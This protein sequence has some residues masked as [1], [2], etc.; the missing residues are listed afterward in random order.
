M[1]P[2]HAIERQAGEPAA[3]DRQL[4]ELQPLEDLQRQPR[5]GRGCTRRTARGLR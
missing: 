2:S 4:D 3:L 1:D 5:V